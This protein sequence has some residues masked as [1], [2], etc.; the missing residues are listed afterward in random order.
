L[1]AAAFATLVA[2]PA[3]SSNPARASW[4]ESAQSNPVYTGTNRSLW[5]SERAQRRGSYGWRRG[6]YE[7]PGY[8]AYGAYDGGVYPG[9]SAYGAYDGGVYDGG[10]Y[11]Y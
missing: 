4:A 6:Y 11:R 10:Y 8:S 3:S 1:I 5:R 7:Y 9:Y 2:G